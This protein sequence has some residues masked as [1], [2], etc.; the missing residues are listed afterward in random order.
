MTAAV[1][2][3]TL[4]G[5]R[6]VE[7][8]HDRVAVGKGRENALVL[9]DDET[10]S[11]LH[12][13]FDRFPAGWCV[14]DLGSTN[15]TYVNGERIFT[16]RRLLHGDRVRVGTTDLVFRNSADVG[17]TVTKAPVASPDVTT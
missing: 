7:L 1:E 8:A 9:A 3:W 15:G 13:V 10:V 16:T 2:V 14:T 17:R 5:R 11:Q 12:A 6:T 4:S